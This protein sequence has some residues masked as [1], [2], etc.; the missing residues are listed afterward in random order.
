VI[1]VAASLGLA[2]APPGQKKPLD[3][4]QVLSLLAGGVPSQRVAMLVNE[5]GI[6]FEPT[7]DYL[8]TLK[9]V[10]AEDV[11]LRA[12]RAAK[13]TKAEAFSAEATELSARV[14]KHLARGA[15]LRQKKLYTE[16]EQE[17]RAALE[18][19]PENPEL[20]YVLGR[21]L[22]EQKKWD[23]AAAEYRTAIRLQPDNAQA[24]NGLGVALAQK[25]DLDGAIAEFRTAIRLQPDNAM[26][27][28]GL[29]LA[30]ETKG[31]RR[32]ALEELRTAYLLDPK[33]SFIAQAY[34]RLLREV[35]Q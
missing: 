32:A 13:R 31:D 30:L 14:Q 2:Q 28:N 9:N 26:A 17:Y 20:H 4:I 12:L 8:T 11:L 33:N 5:R 16:A 22:D 6:S 34:E 25:G 18:L 23:L 1:L 24:H 35:N 27:H 29:G 10:G 15:E 19:E 3:Q 7:E 21:V